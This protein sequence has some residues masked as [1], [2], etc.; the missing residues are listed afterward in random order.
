[1]RTLD[2]MR[3]EAAG[4]LE[5]IDG[6]EV[7]A[8]VQELLDELENTRKNDPEAKIIVGTD[9]DDQITFVFWAS[10]EMQSDFKSFPEV[11]SIDNTYN[12]NKVKMPL[13][14]FLCQDKFGHGKVAAWTLLR[15]EKK[16]T[17]HD[18]FLTF[19]ETYA[20]VK[21]KIRTVFVDKD[22]NEIMRLKEV[23]PDADVVVC[24][25][26]S[27]EIFKRQID[28]KFDKDENK[29]VKGREVTK[30]MLST[31][32]EEEYTKLYEEL[33]T[34]ASDPFMKYFDDN[35]HNSKLVWKGHE[36]LQLVTFGVTTT[37]NNESL[38]GKLKPL[39]NKRR[40][41]GNCFAKLRLYQQNDVNRS[42]MREFNNFAK[43]PYVCKNT[44]P[45][46][47]DIV[48]VCTPF[49]SNL[50]RQ[51]YSSSLKMDALPGPY[52]V[53]IDKCTCAFYRSRGFPCC[54]MFFSRRLKGKQCFN[55]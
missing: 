13:T 18:A 7:S 17:L 5:T 25:F 6:A 28:K 37:N 27:G 46:I 36:R 12:T 41:L 2:Q 8:D 50:I 53:D 3:K 29:R 44:D 30:K 45:T 16:T 55:R 40:S 20:S 9:P 26:H 34:V 11:L 24:R 39:L 52:N 54:H 48:S 33:K 31:E 32:C 38:H 35:W 1:V 43:V 4:D 15:D 22:M 10:S 21:D 42:R 47:R 19:V 51:E 49:V 14:G 23:L